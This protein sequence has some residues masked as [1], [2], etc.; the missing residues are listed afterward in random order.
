MLYKMKKIFSIIF[1]T[2]LTSTVLYAQCKTCKLGT[3]DFHETNFNTVPDQTNSSGT[4]RVLNGNHALGQSYILQNVCGL[5]Y[6]TA[7]VLIETRSQPYSF[8]ANGSG[9]PAPLN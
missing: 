9:F 8:N 3:H 1:F 2:L 4:Q 7:S 6:T 5:T